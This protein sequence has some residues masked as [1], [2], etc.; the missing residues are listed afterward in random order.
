MVKE[1]GRALGDSAAACSAIE[2]DKRVTYSHTLHISDD[3]AVN[4]VAV[5][6]LVSTLKAFRDGDTPIITSAVDPYFAVGNLSK[7]RKLVS[8][9]YDSVMMIMAKSYDYETA[10][11]FAAALVV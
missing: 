10:K 5:G 1:G 6:Q 11:E 8:R 4:D 2:A 7:A 9:E 3:V